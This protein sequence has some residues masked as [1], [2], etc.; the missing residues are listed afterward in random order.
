MG[1]LAH[2][3]C[4]KTVPV[5]WTERPESSWTCSKASISY[6]EVP[7]ANV[8]QLH[9]AGGGAGWSMSVLC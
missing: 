3:H 1:C 8:V 4:S 2:A 5:K 6:E 7:R 9:G